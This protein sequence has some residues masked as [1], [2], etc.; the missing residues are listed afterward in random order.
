MTTIRLHPERYWNI[1]GFLS[2]DDV[3]KI[4]DI[5][6]NALDRAGYCG[7][8]DNG[9]LSIRIYDDNLKQNIDADS[10]AEPSPFGEDDHPYFYEH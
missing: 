5:I 2:D 4:Y 7:C 1:C 9:E 6:D 3:N 10:A 8:A